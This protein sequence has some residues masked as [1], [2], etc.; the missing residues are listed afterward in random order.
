MHR[1]GGQ[2]ELF[3]LVEPVGKPTTEFREPVT[4]LKN[5]NGCQHNQADR[6][7]VPIPSAR[8]QVPDASRQQTNGNSH[9]QNDGN[10][11]C[12]NLDFHDV[13]SFAVICVCAIFAIDKAIY[14]IITQK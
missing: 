1:K 3:V 13:T 11:P 9:R 12:G 8:E 10:N 4:C 2:R 6:P 14:I 7:D 5:E